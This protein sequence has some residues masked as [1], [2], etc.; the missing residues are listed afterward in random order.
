MLGDGI[1]SGNND[2]LMGAAQN[3]GRERSSETR[4]T[5]TRIDGDGG[6][7]SNAAA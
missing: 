7:E 4:N 3:Q 2:G 1:G 5:P 6:G